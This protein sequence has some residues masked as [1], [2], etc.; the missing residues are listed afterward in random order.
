MW[1]YWPASIILHSESPPLQFS[2]HIRHPSVTMPFVLCCIKST[3]AAHSAFVQLTLSWLWYT[4]NL[5]VYWIFCCVSRE[6]LH[7]Y[8]NSLCFLPEIIV[9]LR[10]ISCGHRR[11]LQYV[12]LVRWLVGLLFVEPF[13][14]L[15]LQRSF[16]L[17][18]CSECDGSC[19]S[20]DFQ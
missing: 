19:I 6:T 12:L 13:F 14:M 15:I 8:I 4:Q 7:F 9:C 2:P 16:G 11:W 17:L 1:Q 3:T 5:S 20:T 18:F 10:E